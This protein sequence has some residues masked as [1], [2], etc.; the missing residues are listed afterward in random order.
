M[1][2]LKDIVYISVI[3]CLVITIIYG[4]NII[5]DV[6]N[7]LDLKSEEIKTLET[8]RDSIQDKLDSTAR[9]FAS[10][11]KISDELNQSYE[12]L[13]AS[14]GTLKKK[15]DK[16]ESEYDDLSTTYVN[17]FTDLMGNLTIFETHIQA[18][19]DWFRDQRDISE[20]NE[21]RDVKLDLYSDCLAYDEDSCDIKLTC[22]P[23]TNSYKYNVI[24][25]YDSLNVNKSDFLQN[26]SEIWKNKGGDCEDTAF[27]FTAEYNYLVERCMKLKYDRKQIR[28]FSF[29][30]SSGHNTFLTYH[31]KFYYSDTEPIEVTSFGTYMYPVCGQFLGQSTGHCVV[32]LTDDAISSTSEIYPSLKDAALIEPQKGNYLSSIGSG[33]V[34]YDDNEEIEQSNYISLMMTDDDI[35]YFYTYTGENRWLGYKEFLGDISKQKIELRKLWRDRIADNT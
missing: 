15:T 11:K 7:S 1:R 9:E 16:L 14:H 28:I 19:I 17:E 29:Q 27:L 8:E 21:Y 35:K 2:S 24:Y 4:H 6:N 23:F 31:N 30:P 33:L 10:L 13:A 20:L 3:V 22:I 18:S 25:K 26:L 32:A 34:V 5:I 12:S